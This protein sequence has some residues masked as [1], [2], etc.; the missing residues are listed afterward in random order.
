MFQLKLM[1]GK[2]EWSFEE[3]SRLVFKSEK[4][5][6]DALVGMMLEKGCK[7]N[8]LQH[9]EINEFESEKGFV[10]KVINKN[11]DDEYSDTI[12]MKG[13]VIKLEVVE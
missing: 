10:S 2:L 5:A 6:L 4:K 8:N 9:S 3:Y 1:G 7:A 13:Y 12:A 11:E